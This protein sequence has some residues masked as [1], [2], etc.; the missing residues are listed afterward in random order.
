[1]TRKSK[2][3]RAR[4]RAIGDLDDYARLQVFERDGHK[5][6]RC[7]RAKVQWAHIISRRHK[8]VRWESDN[9][10][11]LCAGCHMWWHEYPTLSGDWFRKNWPDRHERILALYREGGK[12]NV[13]EL[14]EELSQ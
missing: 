4:D 12:V 3:S 10:L 6:V 5:C 2:K 7:G 11:S 13:Q 9:A 14:L 8:T 1:L